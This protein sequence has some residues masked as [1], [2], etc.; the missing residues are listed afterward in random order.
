MSLH[1]SIAQKE[2][3]LNNAVALKEY[4]KAKIQV[5]AD[6]AITPAVDSDT[7]INLKKKE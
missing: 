6:L 5:T 3:Q 4:I 1:F 2:E 7:I